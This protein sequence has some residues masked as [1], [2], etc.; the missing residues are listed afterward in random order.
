MTGVTFSQKNENVI[1]KI[2]QKHKQEKLIN[3]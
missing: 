3:K 2:H 1:N